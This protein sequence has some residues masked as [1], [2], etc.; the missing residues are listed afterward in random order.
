MDSH[1]FAILNRLRS[2]GVAARSVLMDTA[3]LDAYADLCVGEPVPSPARPGF[4]T[5]AGL[6]TVRVR[7]DRGNTRLEQ[8]RIPWEHSLATLSRAVTAERPAA[9]SPDS[10][11]TSA[12]GVEDPQGLA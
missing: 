1:G 10:S 9:G 5:A 8:E 11:G 3:T 12:V 4:L 6:E 2:H 7:A